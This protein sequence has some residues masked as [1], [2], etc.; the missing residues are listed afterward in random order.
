MLW[1]KKEARKARWVDID[2]VGTGNFVSD[3]GNGR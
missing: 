1:K 3:F 2:G